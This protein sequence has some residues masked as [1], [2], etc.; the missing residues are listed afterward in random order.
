MREFM[1]DMMDGKKALQA[2]LTSL[3]FGV[4]A[5]IFCRSLRGVDLD[6]LGALFG[7]DRVGLHKLT[8]H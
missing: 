3:T 8:K 7:P 1:F 2:I 4:V 6:D 5:L